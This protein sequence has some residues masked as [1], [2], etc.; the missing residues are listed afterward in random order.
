MTDWHLRDACLGGPDGFP[1]HDP[2]GRAVQPCTGR[3][4]DVPDAMRA[5]VAAHA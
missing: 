2:G 4:L 3:A 1:P 5:L